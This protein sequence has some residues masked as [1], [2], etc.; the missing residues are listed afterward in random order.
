MI[1]GQGKWVHMTNDFLVVVAYLYIC[2][3]FLLMMLHY[4]QRR[5]N[6]YLLKSFFGQHKMGNISLSNGR[7]RYYL[8]AV[9]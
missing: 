2:L 6:I 1:V 3:G 8:K 5:S 9:Q 7:D 4:I